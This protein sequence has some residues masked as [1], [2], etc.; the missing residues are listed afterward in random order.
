MS[1]QPPPFPPPPTAQT[2]FQNIPAQ[3]WARTA[4]I[5]L[6]FF[7]GAFIAAAATAAVGISAMGAA[8]AVGGEVEDVLG[9]GPSWIVL[10]FQ[11]LNMGFLSP[12]SIGMDVAVFGGFSG[13]GTLFF[14]PWLVPAGGIGAVALTQRFLGGNLRAPHT[15]VRLLLAGLAGVAFAAVITILAAAV[16]FRFAAGF[17]EFGSMWAHSASFVGFL[18][19]ALLVGG[20]TY[21]LLLPRQGVFLQRSLT[22]VAAVFE[23]VITLAV[24]CAVA[25]LI[26]ALVQGETEAALFIVFALP[27]LGFMAFSMLHFIPTVLSGS[28]DLLGS[29]GS[30]TQSMFFLPAPAVIIAIVVML[31]A[32]V[33]TALRW[34]LRTRFRAHHVWAWITLPATYLLVGILLTAANGIYLS[35]YMAGEGFRGGMHTAAWGFIVWLL[36]GG[37]IQALASYVVPR[38]V[39]SLPAGLVRLLG[40]GLELPPAVV[41]VPGPQQHDETLGAQTPPPVEQ[42]A[43]MTPVSDTAIQATATPEA[44]PA[45]S[46]PQSNPA[47][48]A[49]Q[50]LWH[51]SAGAARPEPGGRMQRKTK[52]L[53]GTTLGLLALVGIAWI[54]HTVLARTMFGPQHTAE[55]YLQAVVDGRAEDALQA[56]GPNVTD[57]LRALST[58]DVYQAAADRPGRFEI[59]E[60]HRDGSNAT[61]DASIYQSGKAYPLELELTASGTQAVV[62]KDWELTTGDLA[63]RAVY[64]SGPAH[65]TVNEIELEVAPSGQQASDDHGVATELDPDTVERLATEAGHVLLPGT[66]TFTAPEGSKYLSNGEDLELTITP[67]E[68][69]TTPIEFSQRYTPAFEQDTIAQIEQRLESCLADQT[70]RVADCEAASWED[71]AWTAMSDMV[72]T[73]DT[74]PEIEVVPVG[75]D[76][77]FDSD[78]DLT[79]YSGPVIARITEGRIN[80]TY[81]VRDDEDQDWMERE[82]TYEPFHTGFY[83]P[84][85][86]PV[87][88]DGDEINIDYSPLDEYNPDWL[89]QEFR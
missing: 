79:E 50:D 21:L 78:V 65:L 70:I 18:V 63:G 31:A 23:H 27:T 20:I 54:A 45:P 89:S 7:G 55:A 1:Q 46:S 56:M 69:S 75:S 72:R 38:L 8:G 77:Y 28:E 10:T 25:L 64:M 35:M 88:L 12:L 81:N 73:W 87:T 33:V 67:G 57:E 48:Q 83:E 76:P 6:V 82:Q 59:G 14:V 85:E 60:V 84:M 17:E 42:T 44:F 32:I 51:A 15:G 41:G 24:L 66:Y 29:V 47:N 5:P 30:Q 62:F 13:A 16:R 11:L 61:V 3:A 9:G 19:A 26:T 2:A 39:Y 34:S 53:L 22:A 86:F 71:T 52:V 40:V 58:D 74:S 43:V 36:L 37:I 49:T 80:L 4:L 68:V